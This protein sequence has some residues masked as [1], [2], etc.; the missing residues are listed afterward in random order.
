[1]PFS[2][3][4]LPINEISISVFFIICLVSYYFLFKD[5]H[6]RN[7]LKFHEIYPLVINY[8][9]LCIISFLVLAF[10][11]DRVFTG[12]VYNDEIYEVIKEFVTG[13]AIIS[14]VIINFIFYVKK[15]RVD[16]TNKEQEAREENDKRD[17]KIAEVI[18]LVILSLMFILPI[19]NIFKYIN[20]IDKA[21]QI[22]QTLGGLLFMAI[23]LFLLISLNPLNIKEKFK[24]LIKPNE[25]KK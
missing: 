10:G 12:Y 2:N 3:F 17:L 18:E 4:T 8:L 6:K 11:I 13:F 9:I 5:H 20:Y 19:F 16:L 7:E 21:E 25:S 23:S 15:H 1:M 22:R 24:K 14:V